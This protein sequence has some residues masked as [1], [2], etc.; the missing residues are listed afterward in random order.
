M[1]RLPMTLIVVLTSQVSYAESWTLNL[2]AGKYDRHDTPVSVRLPDFA[3]NL[4]T[5]QLIDAETNQTIPVQISA[6][7]PVATWILKRPLK[8]KH[9]REYILHAS[10]TAPN[11]NQTVAVQCSQK[12]G[13]LLISVGNRTVLQYNMAVNQAPDGLEEIQSRNAYIH[14]VF[15]P[16]GKM[17]T[18]DFAPDHPHQRGI[19][20]AWTKSLFNGK[21]INFWEVQQGVGRIEFERLDSTTDGSVYGEATIKQRFL[22]VRQPDQPIEILSETWTIRV[23]NI[24]DGFLFDLQSDQVCTATTPLVIGPY[25]YGGLGVRGRREWLAPNPDFEMITSNG[26]DRIRGNHTRPQWVDFG[27]SLAGMTS[28]DHPDNFRFPQPVRLHPKK[29]YFCFAPLVVGQFEIGPQQM[30]RSKY[31]FHVYDGAKA[32]A[33]NERIWADYATPPD[34]SVTVQP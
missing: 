30:F 8:A 22:D 1:S 12:D 21:D 7:N 32:T 9:Q 31:R 4:S 6:K 24:S 25:H 14:P 17:I 13:H 26:F 29:P 28:L 15:T 23:F 34:V 33:R 11:K 3:P 19:F 20:F 27:D 2:S 10:E 18:D 5:F 16:N